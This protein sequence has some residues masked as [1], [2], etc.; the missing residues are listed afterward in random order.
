MPTKNSAFSKLND[1]NILDYNYKDFQ[2]IGL[3]YKIN[4]IIPVIL[5]G[6]SGARLWPLSR[7][8]YPKQYL[9]LNGDNTMLQDT[10]L[11]L[12]GLFDLKDIIIICNVEHRFLVADQ[13]KKINKQRRQ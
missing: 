12:K 9:S 8:H 11:R 3:L 2:N 4:N 13:C 6:G 10:I 5:A 7:K 1:V